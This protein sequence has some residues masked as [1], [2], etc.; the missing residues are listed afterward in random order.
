[1]R[2]R[3]YP[4]AEAFE[5]DELQ[6]YCTMLLDGLASQYKDSVVSGK[7][8]LDCKHIFETLAYDAEVCART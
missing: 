5:A 4:Q 8:S 6:A 3:E 7:H 1:M 2:V